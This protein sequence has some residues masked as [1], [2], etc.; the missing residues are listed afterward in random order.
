MKGTNLIV[1]CAIISFTSLTNTKVQRTNIFTNSMS[2]TFLKFI[3]ASPDFIPAKLNQDKAKEFLHNIFSNCKI[4]FTKTDNIEFVDQGANFES[5]SCNYCGHDIDIVV[6][7]RAMDKAHQN[8]F[9]NLSFM[10][11]CCH[12]TTTLNHPQY[13][14]PVGFAKFEISISDPT[15]DIKDIELKQL[16]KILGTKIRKIWAHY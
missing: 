14:W 9:K 1:I 2:S 8:H 12:K 16:E 15:S 4:D 3:P 6:W 7:Q 5:V 10:T 11:P 13:H